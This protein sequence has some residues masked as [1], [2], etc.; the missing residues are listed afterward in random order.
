ML[1]MADYNHLSVE[2]YQVLFRSKSADRACLRK[3]SFN[4]MRTLVVHGK[5]TLSS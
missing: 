1:C 4:G 5:H 3:R 2:S